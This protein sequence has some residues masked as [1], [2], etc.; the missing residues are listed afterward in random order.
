MPI[1]NLEKVKEDKN[2]STRTAFNK[3]KEVGC[4]ETINVNYASTKD[5]VELHTI[6]IHIP[7]ILH[8]IQHGLTKSA[9]R[10]PPIQAD[11]KT[12]QM[13]TVPAVALNYNGAAFSRAGAC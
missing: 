4:K 3:A 7:D 10:V 12:G 6:T 1:N 9:V 2:C 13:L 11:L 8:P 5:N